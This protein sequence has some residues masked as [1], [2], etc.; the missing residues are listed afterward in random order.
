MLCFP[1]ENSLNRITEYLQDRGFEVSP[2][3]TQW[4]SLNKC[5]SSSLPPPL[6]K[7]HIVSGTH[8][9]FSVPTIASSVLFWTL[10]SRAVPTLRIRL[11]KPKKYYKFCPQLGIHG[12]A[13]IPSFSLESI[14]LCLGP[15][16]NI[17]ALYLACHVL[18][19]SGNFR[20]YSKLR[21]V[22]VWAVGL[23]SQ[24]MLS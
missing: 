14:A 7:W 2:S 13:L 16:V 20:S 23:P 22:F 24:L 17:V 9:L 12:G 18:E 6:S 10:A 19:L 1:I 11:S 8:M 21:F 3:K 5:S 4:F 15:P